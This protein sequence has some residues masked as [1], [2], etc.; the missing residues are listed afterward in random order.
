MQDSQP[1]PGI[2]DHTDRREATR[3]LDVFMDWYNTARPNQ[4]VGG[5]TPE[6]AWRGVDLSE[7]KP[8]RVHDEQPVFEVMRRKCRGDPHLP[9]LDIEV[10]WPEAA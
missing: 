5:R 8:V 10:E 7:A 1:G 3:N 2:K 4:A 6:E 9:V